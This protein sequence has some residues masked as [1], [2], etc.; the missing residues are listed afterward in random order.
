MDSDLG[1]VCVLRHV[2][3]TRVSGLSTC[4][5]VDANVLRAGLSSG[6]LF[7]PTHFISTKITWTG[8][9]SSRKS[10]GFVYQF[11]SLMNKTF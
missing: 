7:S 9:R 1:L 4:R 5:H 3:A 2:S 6:C 8:S 10:P 11:I